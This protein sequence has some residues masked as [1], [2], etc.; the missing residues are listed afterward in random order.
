[1]I[2]LW[3]ILTGDRHPAGEIVIS[4]T[5]ALELL[6]PKALTALVGLPLSPACGQTWIVGDLA[7][8][9]D[10]LI[11]RVTKAVYFPNERIHLREISTGIG[12]VSPSMLPRATFPDG[13]FQSGPWPDPAGERP[14]APQN[15]AEK[16]ERACGKHRLRRLRRTSEG[17]TFGQLKRHSAKISFQREAVVC[18]FFSLKVRP[19]TKL[20]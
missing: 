1:V 20:S 17:I 9:F 2:F 3:R 5:L 18:D 7:L 13:V 15:S 6:N 10:T 11:S 4:V 8:G 16:R 14:N 12:A 19:L